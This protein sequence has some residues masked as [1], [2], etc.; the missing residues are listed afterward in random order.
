MEHGLWDM[1]SSRHIT[2]AGQGRTEH[3]I[4]T[5]ACMCG[6]LSPRNMVVVGRE[7]EDGWKRSAVPVDCHV[8]I[9]NKCV[10]KD[11]K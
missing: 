9:Q 2:T 3:G 10:I 1:G 8:R 4:A 5:N 7:G 6:L 11:G